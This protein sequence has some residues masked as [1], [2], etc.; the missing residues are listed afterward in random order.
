[1]NDSIRRFV[2]KLLAFATNW[3][4]TPW[5]SLPLLPLPTEH[6]RPNTGRWIGALW[7]D[8]RLISAERF[9][10]RTRAWHWANRSRDDYGSG[11]VRV[12]P[13][14]ARFWKRLSPQQAELARLRNVTEAETAKLR[15]AVN[16]ASKP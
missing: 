7:Q 9:T 15:L 2:P 8:G 13:Y 16:K 11:V 1:M 4:S 10:S 5:G 6:T 3:G 14:R 12:V